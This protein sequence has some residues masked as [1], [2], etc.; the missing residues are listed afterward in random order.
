MTATEALRLERER[1]RTARVA[2][3]M[4]LQHDLIGVLCDPL[5]SSVLGFVAIHQARK[6]DLIGPVADDVLYAG[7]IAINST[8]AGITHEAAGVAE[9][10][11]SQVGG[12]IDSLIKMIPMLAGG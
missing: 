4:Q 1:R 9:S 5:W 6:M 3:E 11:L 2:Q 10:M 8:R 7:V 12:K